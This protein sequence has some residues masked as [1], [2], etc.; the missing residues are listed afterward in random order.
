MQNQPISDYR[1]SYDRDVH[2]ISGILHILSHLVKPL[3][4][5]YIRNDA[6]DNVM[7]LLYHGKTKIISSVVKKIPQSDVWEKFTVL[8]LIFFVF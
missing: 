3:F 5:I 6:I 8:N 4:N 7:S 1:Y 2:R